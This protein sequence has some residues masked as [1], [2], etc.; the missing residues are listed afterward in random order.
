[1]A[2]KPKITGWPILGHRYRMPPPY[3]V[4]DAFTVT[5]DAIDRRRGL[6]TMHCDK[7]HDFRCT[8]SQWR[9]IQPTPVDD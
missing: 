5:V 7:G 1:M 6:I 2:A 8:R 9:C 4:F 3:G